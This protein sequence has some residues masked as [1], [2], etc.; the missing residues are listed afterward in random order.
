MILNSLPFQIGDTVYYWSAGTCRNNLVKCSH[1]NGE[2]E[3]TIDG[4]T[5]ICTYCSRGKEPQNNRN[6]QIFKTKIVNI[7]INIDLKKTNCKIIVRSHTSASIEGGIQQRP[8]VMF[9][10]TLDGEIIN[11]I[12]PDTNCLNLYK[13]IQDVKESAIE[14]IEFKNIEGK[15]FVLNKNIIKIEKPKKKFVCN[16]QN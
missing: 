7:I 15:Q 4:N 12:I 5:Y 1:C 13:S 10:G 9:S 14:Y 3:K 8:I 6:V 16:K 2:Y 11:N